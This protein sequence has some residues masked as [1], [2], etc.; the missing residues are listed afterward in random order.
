MRA[1]RE[2]NRI[3]TKRINRRVLNAKSAFFSD[4]SFFACFLFLATVL[5]VRSSFF[6]S[7]SEAKNFLKF[8]VGVLS[9]VWDAGGYSHH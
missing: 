5:S 9:C 2:T 1:G 3:E 4:S 7:Q 6:K 8:A